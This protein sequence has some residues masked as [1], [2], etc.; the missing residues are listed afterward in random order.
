MSQRSY[1]PPPTRYGAGVSSLQAKKSAAAIAAPPPTRFGAIQRAEAA[2][3]RPVAPPASRFATPPSPIRAS[4]RGQPS[5][6]AEFPSSA[7]PRSAR[8]G[9]RSGRG[10]VQGLILYMQND[11][12]HQSDAEAMAKGFIWDEAHDYWGNVLDLRTNRDSTLSLLGHAG[13]T[14]FGG[15]TASSLVTTLIGRDFDKSTHTVLELVGCAATSTPARDVD[16]FADQVQTLLN[17]KGMD[18]TV[19]VKGLKQPSVGKEST[20]FRFAN[21]KFVYVT[22][23]QEQITLS[24]QRRDT[25]AR[26]YT[27][28]EIFYN[29]F[30]E[31][32]KT[33]KI[34]YVTDKFKNIRGYLSTPTPKVTH[35]GGSG[36]L[37]ELLIAG[38]ES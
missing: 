37:N 25:Q 29:K 2:R 14:T 6:P 17:A 11:A 24:E 9:V 38:Y 35:K 26:I 7:P 4:R 22:G 10:V 3:V 34:S 30:I 28:P 15:V 16:N 20:L 12:M 18:K 27:D 8:P 21:G 33:A 23:T 32:L 5:A 31:V 1:P 13:L 19:T 36:A